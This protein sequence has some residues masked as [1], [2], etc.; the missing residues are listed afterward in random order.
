MENPHQEIL[1]FGS[2][3]LRLAGP[4]AKDTWSAAA[5]RLPNFFPVGIFNAKP[6]D[7]PEIRA[8]G[9]NAVQSYDSKPETIRKMA[10]ACNR[11]GL[12]FLP[13][14]RAYQ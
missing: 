13:N 4:K 3:S 7:L 2:P 8:A 1:A 6:E 5:V 10:A 12:K 14:F 9:F 11:L